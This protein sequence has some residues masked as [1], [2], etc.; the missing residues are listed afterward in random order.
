MVPRTQDGRKGDFQM[1]RRKFSPE[2]LEASHFAQLK[3][4]LRR[5]TG[6]ERTKYARRY[7]Q[8][9]IDAND[10]YAESFVKGRIRHRR[11]SRFQA[12]DLGY[13]NPW[14]RLIWLKA[15]TTAIHHA[16][17]EG[18]Q[19]YMVTII[20]EPWHTNDISWEIDINAIKRRLWRRLNGLSFIGMIEFAYFQNVAHKGAKLIAPHFQG[21]F[22]GSLSRARYRRLRQGFAG[23]VHGSVG[24][25]R[26]KV[27]H[28][29]GAIDYSIKQPSYG[30]RIAMFGS[31]KFRHFST[32]LWLTQHYSL[33]EHLG[34]YR[35]QDLTVAGGQ[36]AEILR[37]A[38]RYCRHRRP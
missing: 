30:Y 6:R 20:H 27:T 11:L 12:R 8:Q 29:S 15:V 7:A 14:A 2:I 5:H 19:I 17:F 1:K 32:K 13:L 25:Y 24:V 26:R 28:L 23:G 9:L 36:G 35:F 33:V 22:W 21:L 3:K 10:K 34:D 38:K 18:N 16:D 4:E 37:A 31:R